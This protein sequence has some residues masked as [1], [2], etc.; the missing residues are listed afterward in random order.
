MQRPQ[1]LNLLGHRR[2]ISKRASGLV[3]IPVSQKEC[4]YVCRKCVRKAD[5][6]SDLQ[7][8]SKSLQ[9]ALGH[10]VRLIDGFQIGCIPR[11]AEELMKVICGPLVLHWNR[12][13]CSFPLSGTMT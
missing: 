8:T 9:N 11:V 7:A 3:G 13:A 5:R 4:S 10:C 2:S 6:F 12:H 1:G